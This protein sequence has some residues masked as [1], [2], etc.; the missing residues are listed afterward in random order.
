M[1]LLQHS[2]RYREPRDAKTMAPDIRY[3]L[4][5]TNLEFFDG[6]LRIYSRFDECKRTMLPH[7]I[8]CTK[9]NDI[10]KIFIKGCYN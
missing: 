7:Q 8:G 1:S 3:Q 10:V 6:V 2:G 4:I 9:L 5:F